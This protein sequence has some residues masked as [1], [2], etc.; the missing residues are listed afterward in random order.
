MHLGGKKKS[1]SAQERAA[2]TM[3]ALLAEERPTRWRKEIN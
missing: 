3:E 2:T 1:Q